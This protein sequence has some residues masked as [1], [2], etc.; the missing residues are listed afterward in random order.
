MECLVTYSTNAFLLA[1]FI[2]R[3]GLNMD[4][5]RRVVCF[6]ETFDEDMRALVQQAF[7]AAEIY[8]TYSC[9][10]VGLIAYQ[11]PHDPRFHHTNHQALGIEILNDQDQACALGEAGRVVLTDYINTHSTFIRYDI[12]DL[13]VPGE[14]PCGQIDGP[15]FSRVLG[16][17]RGALKKQNGDALTY[18]VIEVPLR[19]LPGMRQNQLIQE[20]LDLIR[21]RY[22]IG[23]EG[24]DEQTQAGIR[25]ILY[26]YLEFEPRLEFEPVDEIKRDETSGKFHQTI[27]NV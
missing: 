18:T 19:R 6:A 26:K 14:C 9:K 25:E 21:V 16:K 3:E 24:N 4:Y 7:P 11:C 15:A 2:L 20:Q 13:V 27:C 1:Q 22:V 23:P 10:E 12:A 8:S 17:V 5:M